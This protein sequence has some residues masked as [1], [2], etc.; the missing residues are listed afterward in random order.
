MP[1]TIELRLAMDDQ[2]T[3]YPARIH[4]AA[5]ALLPVPH[6]GDLAPFSASPPVHQG[7]YAIWRL[8]WLGQRIPE[9][10]ASTVTFGDTH[11]D[12]LERRV[13]EHS[14]AELTQAR[15]LR[16]AEL[17]V[18]SPLY[19]SRN[20]RDLPLPEPELIVR[21]LL[22][23]WDRYAPL[24]LAIPESVR[25]GLLSTVYLVAMNGSTMAGSVGRTTT[26]TGFVGTVELGITRQAD[27]T[28]AAL[29]AAL[30]HFADI[31]GIGAQTAHGFGAVRLFRPHPPPAPLG[32][33]LTRTDHLDRCP[34]CLGPRNAV[35]AGHSL[36]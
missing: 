29:F 8:G 15:P 19:F 5:C 30:V 12:V 1:A 35:C 14:F 6:D 7:G 32:R 23:R 28:V 24:P 26:Q 3:I 20:G 2:P 21:S 34:K 10:S 27:D 36:A 18:I 13:E 16:R 4:G 25:R 31:A 22:N 11:H 9:V 33:S 17:D